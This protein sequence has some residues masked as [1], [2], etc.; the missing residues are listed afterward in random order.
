MI[1]EVE[2]V[3]LHGHQNIGEAAEVLIRWMNEIGLKVRI[4]TVGNI[5]GRYEGTDDLA[6]LLMGSHFDTVPMGGKFDGLAG[7]MTSL[8]VLTSM[9]EKEIKT[10]P[11]SR[12]GC[13]YK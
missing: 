4:D 12:N 8:E 9:R 5:F 2:S 7:I 11:A 1:N 10:S 6:P 3:G 13:V